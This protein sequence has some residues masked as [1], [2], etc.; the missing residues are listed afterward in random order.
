MYTQTKLFVFPNQKADKHQVYVNRWLN[1]VPRPS[2]DVRVKWEWFPALGKWTCQ[3]TFQ[4]T[5]SMSRIH[6][7]DKCFERLMRT[8]E[9]HNKP[10]NS[11]DF[12]DQL[13]KNAKTFQEQLT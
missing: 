12:I 13:H 5:I 9:E 11:K 6:A 8:E 1:I 2:S 7:L 4:S 10:F 3:V